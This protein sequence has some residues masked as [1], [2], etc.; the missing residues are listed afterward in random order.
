MSAGSGKYELG[1]RLGGGGMADVFRAV[2]RGA[3]GFSR[4]VAIKRIKRSISTDKSFAK[5][6]VTEARLAAKLHHPNVVQTLDFERDERGCFYLVMELIDGVDLRTLVGSGRIPV[7]ACCFIISEVLRGLDYAHE[8]VDD[9]HPITIIHR[10]ISPHNIMLGWQGSVKIVDFGIAKAVEGSLVSRSGSLKGKVAYMSPEQVHGHSLDGRSDLFAVGIILHE[11][12]TGERLFVGKTEAETLSKVLTQPVAA[13][14]SMNSLVPPDLDAIV[15][16]LLERDRVDR[17]TRARDAMEALVDSSTSIT[18]GRRDLETILEERF[19]DK[20]PIRTSRLS[21]SPS[22]ASSAS[23]G[24]L[25]S[26]SAQEEMGSA[27]TVAVNVQELAQGVTVPNGAITKPVPK[28]TFT[29]EPALDLGNARTAEA[30][31][32]AA[33]EAE[34]EPLVP[35]RKSRLLLVLGALGIA[36]AGLV[37]AIVLG[38]GGEKKPTPNLVVVEVKGGA[39]E[40]GG[41]GGAVESGAV[42]GGA[43]KGPIAPDAAIAEPIS[44]AASRDLAWDAAVATE[45]PSEGGKSGKANEADDASDEKA[46]LTI[47]VIPWATVTVDGK[48]YGQTPQTMHLRRGKHRIV[49]ENSGLD[50]RESFS[51]TLKSGQ[52]KTVN[53]NWQ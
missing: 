2:T 28:R 44:D 35:A 11:L 26:E 41:A 10:D 9:G 13:P 22:P 48:N 37:V 32:Q 53:K 16:R 43:V 21:T 47:R 8:L 34:E 7:S 49:L 38:G 6:F 29:A 50:R 18:K 33:S 46:S 51:M 24:T 40:D 36:A 52:K 19:P 3:E 27:A 25:P 20:A 45:S 17:F 39:V 14:S 30:P 31:A 12:L 23:F 4:P 1:E 5:L 15:M 42:K